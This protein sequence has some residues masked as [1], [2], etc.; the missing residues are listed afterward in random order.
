MVPGSPESFPY[1]NYT[2]KKRNFF[3]KKKGEKVLVSIFGTAITHVDV[4][5]IHSTDFLH[6][7][8]CFFSVLSEARVYT[9]LFL[10]FRFQTNFE[11]FYLL[12]RIQS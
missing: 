5:V 4:K 10:Q 2:S 8:F 6:F 12:P 7:T 11:Y 1:V 3:K 9:T